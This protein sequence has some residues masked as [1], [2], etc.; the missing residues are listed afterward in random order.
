MATGKSTYSHSIGSGKEE[1]YLPSIEESYGIHYKVPL[2]GQSWSDISFPH[3]RQWYY[4]EED[5]GSPMMMFDYSSNCQEI[6]SAPKN[7]YFSDFTSRYELLFSGNATEEQYQSDTWKTLY[8]NLLEEI[9]FLWGSPSEGGAFIVNNYYSASSPAFQIYMWWGLYSKTETVQEVTTTVYKVAVQN[10]GS[11]RHSYAQLQHVGWCVYN[12]VSYP[13]GGSPTITAHTYWSMLLGGAPNKVYMGTVTGNQGAF[14][15]EV[16]TADVTFL[17][18]PTQQ[19]FYVD[20]PERAWY[21]EGSSDNSQ[22]DCWDWRPESPWTQIEGVPENG[23]ETAV[24]TDN[25]STGGGTI[26]DQTGDDIDDESLTDLNSLTAIN[27]G[28]VTLYRPTTSE[29]TSFANFLYTGITDSIAN[30]LKKLV[31]N[32][33][34]YVIFVALCKFAPPIY[35]REEI[36]FCGVGSGVSAD[37]IV[38]QFYD[39]DCGTIHFREQYRSFLDYSPNSKVKIYLPFGGIHELNIDECMG[40]AISVKYRID[41]LSGSAVAKVKIT[42]DRRDTAPFDCSIDSFIY[43]YPCNVYLTMPLSATDWR[44]TYQSLVSLA[45]GVVGGVAT[46]GVGGAMSIATSVA[47][48]VTSNKVSVSRSGQIG[49]SYGY[50]GQDDPY[51]ILERPI[52]SVPSQYESW[53]GLNSNILE[54]VGNMSGYTEIDTD[55]MWTDSFGYATK[56]ECDMIKELFNGGIYL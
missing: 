34:D 20:V 13:D 9:S 6:S 14:G 28:L 51:L 1:I 41:L 43:E 23:Y 44:G 53:E 4:Y 19:G 7:I 42:R 32:P 24:P 49:S 56:E 11:N 15:L 8:N 2:I 35:G 33:L 37:K 26:P 45:G 54:R 40:S 16:A 29:L 31:T 25:T 3:G 38:N 52:T 22:V 50:L 17:P 48:A 36:A 55:T 10:C 39:L 27:S 46:G 12:S 30:Q 5:T 21:F 18:Y 47:S